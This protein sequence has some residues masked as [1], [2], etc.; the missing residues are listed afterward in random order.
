MAVTL[1]SS[2]SNHQVTNGLVGIRVPSGS[3]NDILA[4]VQGILYRDG[5]WT[6][7]GPNYLER[8]GW[9]QEPPLDPDPLT[10]ASTTVV[11]NTSSL[12]VL[13]VTYTFARPDFD[14]GGVVFIAGGVGT[15][16]TTITVK[17]GEPSILFEEEGDV[18]IGYRFNCFSGLSPDRARWRGNSASTLARGR[19]SEGTLYVDWNQRTPEDAI[20][21]LDYNVP[22]HVSYSS[23]ADTR[24]AL[25]LW[26]PWSI[27]TGY[28]WMIFNQGA[29]STANLLG[30]F[31]GRASRVI[32]CYAAGAGIYHGP[33]GVAGVQVAVQRMGPT[34]SYATPNRFGWG[35]FI[36]T[37]ADLLD[38][39]EYQP[40][41]VQMNK[42]SGL[43]D[44]VAGYKTTF[45]DP[46]SGYGDLY[47][48]STANNA[49]IARVRASSDEYA[50]VRALDA[51]FAEVVDLWWENDAAALASVIDVVQDQVDD[52]TE[53]LTTR[54][55]I[56]DRAQV[57]FEGGQLMIRTL[58]FF[59]QAMA[60]PLISASQITAL[61]NAMSFF[62]NVLWDDDFVPFQDDGAGN[63][64]HVLGLGL[65]NNIAQHKNYRDSFA[66]LLGADAAWAARKNIAVTRALDTFKSVVNEFGSLNASTAYYAANTWPVANLMLQIREMLG[67][68]YFSS[69]ARADLLG[70]FLLDV[71][72]PPE[73]RYGGLRKLVAFS[74]A[75]VEGTGLHGVIATGLRP[76]NPTLAAK[77]QQS[78]VDQ[79][80]PH[81]GFFGSS[82]MMIDEAAAVGSYTLSSAIH[83]G[84]MY[85]TRA[86]ESGKETALWVVDGSWYS[87]H[88]APDQGTLSFYGYGQPISL[89]WGNLY[90]PFHV[91]GALWRGC[92]QP[93]DTIADYWDQ[94]SMPESQGQVLWNST[95]TRG[96]FESS[97]QTWTRVAKLAS[98][99]NRNILAV[100][101]HSSQPFVMSLNLM[102]AGGVTPPVGGSFSPPL[103]P[104]SPLTSSFAA[105][106]Y[107]WR[108]AGQWGTPVVDFDMH[109]VADAAFDVRWDQW[110]H[111]SS[112]VTD[113][114]QFRDAT[115]NDFQE[116]MFTIRIR[117]PS[118]GQLKWAIVPYPRGTP[119]TG[120]VAGYA[121]GL[122]F[123][124]PG[125]TVV[126]TNLLSYGDAPPEDP[127]MM[128]GG[129][130][131]MFSGR[132]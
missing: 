128:L 71:L 31:S 84:Y 113:A 129:I 56:Y 37:K 111:T 5:T 93:A 83:S 89:S 114:V 87:D 130:L 109:V 127:P 28:Y 108:L 61:K 8:W 80:N 75:N 30:I 36:S 20:V 25:V 62:A 72:S 104:D 117:M 12:V 123:T 29:A 82:L 11:T 118:G 131:A 48:G 102:A 64:T 32:G 121:D 14:F 7:T 101:D 23:Q 73:D 33:A 115:G 4:P 103:W 105:G 107:R 112:P 116:T 92:V 17:D 16:S 125:A 52:L 110:S 50:R 55:G 79:G 77:L 44:R 96:V 26:D 51:T 6:G 63:F 43:A 18:D 98:V 42:H 10:A 60:H 70:D 65:A 78:W 27:D 97:G 54:Q 88:R 132:I 35:L 47:M 9:Y 85:V 122:Q 69:E 94:P 91:S 106:T 45:T 1:G 59:D 66:V 24:P 100:R 120:T 76:S 15:H 81:T 46:A 86:T 41:N 13:K 34:Q 68:D 19:R 99:E 90:V 124:G 39:L 57:Y 49:L 22:Y 2:G 58:L 67:T 126:Q 21:D 95:S 53:A 40:I 3:F 38:E 74:D 119:W